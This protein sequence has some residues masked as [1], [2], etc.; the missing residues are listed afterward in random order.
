MGK[1]KYFMAI[2]LRGKALEDAE[3]IKESLG[4]EFGLKGALRSPSHITLHRPFE[5]SEEK[6]NILREKLRSFRSP[7]PYSILLQGFDAFPRRVVFVAVKA[8]QA[9]YEHYTALKKFAKSE[10]GL[11]NEWVDER[12]FHPHVT[13]A[14]RDLK[15]KLFQPVVDF[16]TRTPFEHQCLVEG[17][18]LLKLEEKWEELEHFPPPGQHVHYL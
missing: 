12:G 15:P 10:L 16:L 7:P 4:S 5:W 11:L 14:F 9:L 6:E 18:S 2:I 1:R 17:F 13:V 3:K 8:D